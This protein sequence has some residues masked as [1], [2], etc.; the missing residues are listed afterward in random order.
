MKYKKF[1]VLLRG[2]LHGDKI[3]PSDDE[4]L[5]GLVEYSLNMISERA[6]SLHLLTVNKAEIIQR[7][8]T[9][10]YMI[11]KPELPEKDDDEIDIDEDLCFALARYTASLISKE[12]VQLHEEKAEDIIMKYNQKVYQ[13]LEKIKF[14]AENLDYIGCNEVCLKQDPNEYNG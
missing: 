11:R 10:S 8:A 12:K 1:K 5:L 14:D 2:L 7:M 6:E 13:I 3:V 4:T 9:G